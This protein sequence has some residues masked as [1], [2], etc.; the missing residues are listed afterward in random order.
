MN[1]REQW[2]SRI[3]F[4]L[5]AV[6]SAIGLGNI[7]RFPYMAY[8][9]GGGAFL[10][11]YIFAMLTAGI[12]FMILEF[13]LGHKFRGSAPKTFAA[14]NPKWEWLGWMQVLVAFVISVY[15]IA[16]IGWSIAYTGFAVTQ[17]WGEAPKDFFFGSFLGLT[18]SPF[19]LG[20]IQNTILIAMLIGWGITWAACVSGVKTGIERAGKVLM[21]TL[22]V[23]LLVMIARVVSL[24][25]AQEGL[26]WL[27]KPD[28][29]AL[30]NYK[31]WV[32]A[33][34]QIFFT[35]SIG[36]AIMIAYSSYLPK[37]A[38]INNN[39][40]MT[41]FINCGFS[42]A[43]GVMIF[44]VLGYMA[45]KQ[46]VGVNE[47]VSGGVGLAFITIPTAINLMPMPALF[48]TL[49][50]LSLTMAGVSSHISIVEA[51]ISAFM[52][53]MEWSR[54]KATN[55]I[56]G[57][58]LVVS[59]AFC[60][61]A[62]LLILDIVDHFINNFGIM[63][64]ALVEIFFVAW[65]CNL[66]VVRDHVNRNSEFYVGTVWSVCLRFVTVPMLAF[67]FVTNLWGDLSTLYGGY[68]LV[69]IVTL[70][71]VV[72]VATVVVGFMLQARRSP[73]DFV[74]ITDNSLRR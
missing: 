47:V 39:A 37:K 57:V 49:F 34:G 32:A 68:S 29:S 69:S 41:V 15:Y 62:G 45:A 24:P 20:G 48:G 40:C 31:V 70:G 12:P 59:L 65:L 73:A 52:D 50:F 2:G 3:G 9:N 8:E 66:D 54:A 23:L 18:G 10:I 46:G 17:A 16:I 6:G 61:G 21:P 67:L 42:M 56:C 22:F 27:F 53:K 60:T 64:A 33:Y 38:D 71:W 30:S 14:I 74:S 36:F 19:D 51:C 13:G 43:A 11:P 44:S 5:A 55:I 72:F 4:I 1:E 58:G 35:L 63:G 25:G 26:N 7:W 28:F